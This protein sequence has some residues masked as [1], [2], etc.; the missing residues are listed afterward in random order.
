MLEQR[1]LLIL[2]RPLNCK[3]FTAFNIYA[4][5]KGDLKVLGSRP[6]PA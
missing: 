3:V 4:S 6:A 2:F 5:A 1:G